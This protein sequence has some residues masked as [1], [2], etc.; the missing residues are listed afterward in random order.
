[1]T[2]ITQDNTR[3]VEAFIAK[4]IQINRDL[5]R[6][7]S[8]AEDHFDTDPEKLNWTDV[9]EIIRVAEALQQVSDMV[10][11]EGEYAA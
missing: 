6:L 3:Q 8:A 2:R 7:K 11:Q 10:F 9:A 4:I 5:D 1:M